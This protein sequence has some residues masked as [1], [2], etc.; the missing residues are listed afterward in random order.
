MKEPYAWALYLA[1]TFAWLVFAPSILSLITSIICNGCYFPDP[2][3]ISLMFFYFVVL[4]VMLILFFIQLIY[5]IRSLITNKPK[6]NAKKVLLNVVLG[7]LV[8]FVIYILVNIVLAFFLV[9]HSSTIN[10]PK[11]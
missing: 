8:G 9:T 7:L 1:G 6:F 11:L 5:N 4:A 2:L 3:T 10:L